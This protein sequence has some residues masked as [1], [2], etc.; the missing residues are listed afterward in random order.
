VDSSTEPKDRWLEVAPEVSNPT[1]PV[2]TA[3]ID[4]DAT[5]AAV[6]VREQFPQFADAS[7]ATLGIGW[8]NAAYLFAERVVFRFPRRR[9]G[10][11]LIEREI[12]LLP[13]LAPHLSL[14]I[15]VPRF[16]GRPTTSYPWPFAGSELISGRTA[17]G[18][19]L[20]DQ[21]RMRLALPLARFLRA[22]HAVEAAPLVERGL[23]GDTIGRLDP[24]RCV[25]ATRER[26]PALA[27]AG[28]D[29]AGQWAE[30]LEQHPPLSMAENE[31]R[32]VHGDLYARHIVLGADSQPVGVIDWGDLHLGDPALDLAVAYLMLPQQAHAEFRTAYGPID[33]RTWHAARYRAVYHAIIEINYGIHE[34]DLQMRDI[35]LTALRL[36]RDELG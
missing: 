18:V 35:G 30:W 20:S 21:S 32:V 25:R 9:I 22:L 24:Q 16:V 19:D 11:A 1:P 7:I 17:C 27:A 5:L 13:L 6:L 10:A 29:D 36:M 15:P 4:I 26:I 31:R 2:W 3:D 8:D 14:A 12:A 23:T 34:N 28:I 33:E